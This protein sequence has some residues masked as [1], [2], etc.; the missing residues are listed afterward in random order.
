MK[1]LLFGIVCSVL[2]SFSSA[3]SG[4][5][6]AIIDFSGG[7]LSEPQLTALS[8]IFRSS[9]IGTGRYD[10]M[11]RNNMSEILQEQAFQLTGEC[12]DVGCLVEVGQILGVRKMFGGVIGLLGSKYVIT[13][14]L[15]DVQTSRIEKIVTE[16]FIGSV[17]DLDIPI[18]IIVEKI[19]E[20]EKLSQVVQKQTSTLLF[21]NSKPSNAT[22]FLDDELIGF[23]PVKIPI[24]EIKQY[25]VKIRLPDYQPWSELLIPEENQTKLINATLYKGANFEDYERE[26]KEYSEAFAWSIIPGGG[27]FYTNQMREGLNFMFYRSVCLVI[28]F[29]ASD[30]GEG[31]YKNLKQT[32]I[33][34]SVLGY[35]LE[36]AYASV[37]VYEYNAELRKKFNIT[38]APQIDLQGSGQVALVIDF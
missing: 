11:D 34:I 13:V 22:V 30:P 5:P 38:V 37:N 29:S 9:L 15:I 23:T 26:K 1:K 12:T 4:D 14:K 16:K 3:F 10:V 25:S 36:G 21:V 19:T 8:D 32:M 6:V 27:F 2:I 24:Y 31:Q 33:G 35:L 17:E 7:G 28:A 18:E 20:S